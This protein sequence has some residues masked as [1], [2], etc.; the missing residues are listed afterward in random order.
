MQTSTQTGQLAQKASKRVQLRTV[1][2][3]ACTRSEFWWRDVVTGSET[4]ALHTDLP[5]TRF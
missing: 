2:V 5:H 4:P 1:V 3:G